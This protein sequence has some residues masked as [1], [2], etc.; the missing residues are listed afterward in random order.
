MRRYHWVR[1][2][3]LLL[4]IILFA[5]SFFTV[6]AGVRGIFGEAVRQKSI[7]RGVQ[8]VSDAE[9]IIIRKLTAIA[10]T[11]AR[12][13]YD[14]VSDIANGPG[15]AGLSEEDLERNFREGFGR[16]IRETVGDQHLQICETLNSY[17]SG[18]AGVVTVD[19]D[20]ATMLYEQKDP[21]GKTVSFRIKNVTISY[22]HPAAGSRMETA[23]FEIMFPEAVFHAGSDEL[24]GYC[25]VARKGIYITGRTS[26]IIGNVFAG[27]HSAEECRDAEI[28]YGETGTYGGMNILSTQ[29]GVKADRIVSGGDINVNGS[30]V[31]MS[32]AG[33]SLECV[34]QR[35]NEIG[36][37]SK[38]AKITLNGTFIPVERTGANDPPV[39]S[40]AVKLADVSLSKLSGIEIYYDTDND[41]G[42]SEKY[43]KLLSSTDIEIRHDLTGIVATPGNVIIHNDVNIEGL[44]L[45]GDRIYAMGNNNIVANPEVAGTIIAREYAGAYG[46]RVSDYIGGMKSAGLKDPEYYVI[47]CK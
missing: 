42:Y 8:A 13:E 7:V 34:A 11:S 4:M 23:G 45:C 39:F 2:F 10:E 12:E 27:G 37:F 43:R 19:D 41:A 40:E 24:F 25:M 32:P 21:D 36:G 20:P 29:L 28:V 26:S 18:Y 17:L 30:F 9:R 35:M 46:M 6:A 33:D 16:R 22:T 38:D 15:G 1:L 31:V 14:R 3:A 5:L 47:P 44:I